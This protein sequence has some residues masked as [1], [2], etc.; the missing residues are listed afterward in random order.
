M[1]YMNAGSL[2]E[3]LYNIKKI[4]EDDLK[5]F[6]YQI[7]EGLKFLHK[8]MD[9]WQREIKPSNILFNFDGHLKLT[10]YGVLPKIYKTLD[11]RRIYIRNEKYKAPEILRGCEHSSKS[12]IW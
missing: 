6:I 10:D 9:N 12:D 8:N 11:C 2:K 5:L 7:L 3:M 1:E 4:N